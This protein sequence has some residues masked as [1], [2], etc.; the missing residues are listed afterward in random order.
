MSEIIQLG[1]LG[2]NLDRSRAKNL[3]D[4]LGEQEAFG[5]VP[6]MQG[7]PTG[8]TSANT[9]LFNGRKTLSEFYLYLYQGLNAFKHF[10]GIDTDAAH[11]EP[12]FLERF[13]LE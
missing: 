8:L 1:L 6:T 13:P 11:V 4:V 12:L 10:A 3:H 2:N 7:L 5:C 9:V